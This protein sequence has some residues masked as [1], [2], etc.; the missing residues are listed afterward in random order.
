MRAYCA[1]KFENKLPIRDLQDKL[2][3]RRHTITYDW[4]LHEDSE[5]DL[6]TAAYKDLMGVINCNVFIMIWH[7]NIKGANVELGC[8][9]GLRKHIIIIGCPVKDQPNVFFHHPDC[10]HFD[11]VENALEMIDQWYPNGAN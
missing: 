3:Q 11:T 5:A 6:S 10:V 4:S 1:S 9:L 8:A 2:R 7:P